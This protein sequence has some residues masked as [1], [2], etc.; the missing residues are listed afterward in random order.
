MGCPVN[1]N[2]HMFSRTR[3]RLS[4]LHHIAQYCLLLSHKPILASQV[5]SNLD[6]GYQQASIMVEMSSNHVLNK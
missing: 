6:P 4:C 1:E 3:Q 2:L 5:D